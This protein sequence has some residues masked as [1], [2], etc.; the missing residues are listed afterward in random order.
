MSE[1]T[2][3][4]WICKQNRTGKTLDL[5]ELIGTELELY[6]LRV[7]LQSCYKCDDYNLFKGVSY[8]LQYKEVEK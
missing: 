4:E 5:V 2:K 7:P 1:V 3:Q 8:C 6:E